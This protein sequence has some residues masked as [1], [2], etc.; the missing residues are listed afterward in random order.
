M[1]DD[2]TASAL[3]GLYISRIPYAVQLF[4]QIGRWLYVTSL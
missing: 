1:S 4:S 3:V 2:M